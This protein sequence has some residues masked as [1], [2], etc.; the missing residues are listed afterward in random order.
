M[1]KNLFT[2]LYSLLDDDQKKVV[3]TLDGPILVVA[4]PGT[5]KT[6]VLALR[7]ANILINRDLNPDNILCLTFSEAGVDQIKKRLN[8]IV[9]SSVANQIYVS[10]YHGFGNDI[11]NNSLIKD[12]MLNEL[13][14]INELGANHIIKEIITKLPYRN[15]LKNI[16]YVRS[17]KETISQAKKAYLNYKDI[18]E[19]VL[20]NLEF[21][22]EASKISVK[23]SDKLAKVAKKNIQAFYELLG[24]ISTIKTDRKVDQYQRYAVMA[25]KDALQFFEEGGGTKQVTKWKN[26]Y[27]AKNSLNQ[28]IF[29]NKETNQ[30][31]LDFCEVF[32]LY[33]EELKN[34]KL[35]DFDDMIL[36]T[37]AYLKK[38]KNIK[39]SL[40]EQFQYILLDEYQDTNASQANLVKLLTDNPVNE[41]KPN[42]L[43][44]GDDDQ[45][46]Y[47]FQGARYSHMLE[48]FNE[49]RDVQ[50]ITL[51]TNY[52]SN[53]EIVEVI[54]K[55]ATKIESRLE[56]DLPL[57]DKNF[58]I[59][60]PKEGFIRR[61]H[62]KTELEQNS[63]LL[64][65][66]KNK[67]KHDLAI[68]SSKHPDLEG[69]ANLLEEADLS[70]D[71][72]RRQNILES[73]Y[74]LE[75][76]YLA[77]TIIAI[78]NGDESQINHLMPIVLNF[79]FLK[80]PTEL[81]WQMSWQSLDN[82]QNW[83]SIVIKEPLTSDIFKFLL[84]LSAKLEILSYEQII[85]YLLGLASLDIGNEEYYKSNFLDY[86]SSLDNQFLQI[87]LFANLKS[88]KSQLEDYFIAPK[89]FIAL[90]DFVNFFDELKESDV[91]LT[92]T[93]NYKDLSNIKVMTAHG[94]KGLEFD[95][96]YLISANEKIWGEDYRSDHNKISLPINLRYL[97]SA[98]QNSRDQRLRLL[99]VATSRARYNLNILSYDYDLGNK[100][101]KPLSYLDENISD[102]EAISPYLKNPKIKRLEQKLELS[103]LKDSWKSE[104]RPFKPNVSINKYLNQRITEYKLSPTA[105]N[106]FLNISNAGPKSFYYR[107][108]LGYPS[109]KTPSL[110]YGNLIHTALEWLINNFK[111]TA[112]LKPKKDL[113]NYFLN[114]LNYLK[115]EPIEKKNLAQRG[116]EALGN[117]YQKYQSDFNQD[118]QIELGFF[119]ED[120]R[121]NNHS[122]SGKIDRL[123]KKERALVIIDY[124]TSSKVY[125]KWSN[126][127]TLY[128]YKRQLYFYHLL[129]SNSKQFKGYDQI[130]ARVDYINQDP[131]KT[132][133]LYL[134]LDSKEEQRFKALIEKVWDHILK[135]DFPDPKG[136]PKS[137]SGIIKFENDLLNNR[138]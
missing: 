93:I 58:K 97:R 55:I 43:A 131:D 1:N 13:S 6:Q 22:D 76:V 60:S 134:D 108:L 19:I 79:E 85:D 94:S 57:V 51:K 68:I 61:L 75:I 42:I 73:Q 122:I 20:D 77:K 107:H 106:D 126:Q 35:Y 56:Y 82:R 121:V 39:Y 64:N 96:V 52:R 49:F 80:L 83:S 132:I 17:I 47:A 101:M 100:L 41:N 78:K 137:L 105:L 114:N 70:I 89:S 34:Q 113:I 135:L 7:V 44:V 95:T 111:Q 103:F 30:R 67:P 71:Y 4:G 2:K 10:T 18:E 54:K 15:S 14:P 117:Y 84:R 5:G 27:L 87:E 28:Q 25:L 99:Y 32:K 115:L 91:K 12:S 123:T 24:Q 38:N 124:K 40:Q 31:L 69:I 45:A 63:W 21:I 112:K 9:G 81:I 48:F 102:Q 62:F 125:T 50:I 98:D 136:Y 3:D 8:L 90:D 138:I 118:D 26:D 72:K 86:L 11:L 128:N 65:E 37:I 53:Q 46:I 88:L 130:K 133:S 23:L 104:Y 127:E 119:N 92:N 59:N 33:Q 129:V 109:A 74:F 116:S 120:I 66:L 36:N 16:I 29:N 110:I